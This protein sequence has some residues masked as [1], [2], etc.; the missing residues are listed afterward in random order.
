MIESFRKYIEARVSITPAEW[1][2][3]E[4]V[5]RIKKLRKKQYLLQEGDVW[6]YHAFISL[7]CLRR[8]SIDAKGLEHI[9]GF[10]AE[11]WWVGDRESLLS[12][13]PSKINIDAIEDSE[14]VL[15]TNH[16]FET[17]CKEIPSF[18]RMIDDILQKSFNVAQERIQ[19]L[20]SATAEERYLKFIEDYPQFAA[21]V[22]QGMIAS[23]LGI[24]PE[25][26]SR[27]RKQVSGK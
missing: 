4:S 5:C 24:T 22:P 15:M 17:L 14:V 3:I 7:G 27:V 23:F 19:T 25:T 16:D 6:R 11:N 21:R 18:R 20:I 9:I 8:F 12:G 13:N 26:L 10:S 1:E 2:R